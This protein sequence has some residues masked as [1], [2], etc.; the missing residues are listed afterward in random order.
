VI[1]RALPKR[2]VTTTMNLISLPK[3][4]KT[5]PSLALDVF[6]TISSIFKLI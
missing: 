2:E 5:T 6:I 3:E 1:K 4:G